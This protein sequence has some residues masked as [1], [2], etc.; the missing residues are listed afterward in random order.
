MTFVSHV[1]NLVSKVYENRRDLMSDIGERETSGRSW[2]N[3]R[4]GAVEKQV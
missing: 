2:R 3:S 4:L 1:A